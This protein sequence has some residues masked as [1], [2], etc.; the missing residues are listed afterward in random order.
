MDWHYKLDPGGAVT[1]RHLDRPTETLT[2]PAEVIPWLHLNLSTHPSVIATSAGAKQTRATC[3]ASG[4][5]PDGFADV[6]LCHPAASSRYC[7]DPIAIAN[8]DH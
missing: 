1:I 8:A 4:A 2:I 5:K 3:D 7:L 6:R